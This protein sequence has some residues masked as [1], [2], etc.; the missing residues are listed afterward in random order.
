[1]YVVAGLRIERGAVGAGGREGR[2]GVVEGMG[3]LIREAWKRAEEEKVGKKKGRVEGGKEEVV[4]REDPRWE[5]F[6]RRLGVVEEREE[7]EEVEE[8]RRRVERLEE[9]LRARRE[10]DR[11]PVRVVRERSERLGL[12]ALLLVVIAALVWPYVEPFF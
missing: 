4:V 1:M 8:L 9:E 5:E 10:D 12:N 7:V 11:S 2:L 3:R 6:L